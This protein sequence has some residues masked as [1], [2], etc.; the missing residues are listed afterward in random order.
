M[1]RSKPTGRDVHPSIQFIRDA[2]LNSTDGLVNLN[3]NITPIPRDQILDH[4][5]ILEAQF[6][7]LNIEMGVGAN[8]LG[9]IDDDS[10]STAGDFIYAN[11][12]D[13]MQ[14]DM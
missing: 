9:V 3:E 1:T 14:G 6:E 8:L 5:E 10:T 12:H 4:I 2:I 13:T 7:H 11:M